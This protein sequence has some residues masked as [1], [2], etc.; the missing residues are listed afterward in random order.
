MSAKTAL[1]LELFLLKLYSKI[2]SIIS[3]KPCTDWNNSSCDYLCHLTLVS[4]KYFFFFFVFFLCSNE[5]FSIFFVQYLGV[6]VGIE[7]TA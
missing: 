4:G 1:E 7:P 6:T 3:R 5:H 2:T